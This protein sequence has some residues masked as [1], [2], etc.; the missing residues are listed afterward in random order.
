[1]RPKSL[2]RKRGATSKI[3]STRHE[4]MQGMIIPDG[5]LGHWQ[6]V[7][8]A[9]SSGSAQMDIRATLEDFATLNDDDVMAALNAID[10]DV[11]CAMERGVWYWHRQRDA[12]AVI[13]VAAF[14][15]EN[16]SAETIRQI[17]KLA[18]AH[19]SSHKG[20][21]TNT[22]KLDIEFATV[23]AHRFQ[24][25]TGERPT[26]ITDGS[27]TFMKYALAW[28]AAVGR[29]NRK[30]G[31]PHKDMTEILRVG[32]RTALKKE[33]RSHQRGKN[34]TTHTQSSPISPPKQNLWDVW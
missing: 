15:L 26:T 2:I 9:H 27:T 29:L 30:K 31:M 34:L 14:D 6:S 7:Y 8:D 32:V 21:R 5:F 25:T 17:A 13:P 1:M 10:S 18:I 23:L 28:F 11:S 20:G 12:K 24:E 33:K 16:Y 3:R 4:S 22:R 19:L